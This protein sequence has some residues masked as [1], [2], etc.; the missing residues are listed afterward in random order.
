MIKKSIQRKT[1][2]K[3]ESKKKNKKEKY[4]NKKKMLLINK[5]NAI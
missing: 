2:K 4:E 3:Y 1:R 5:N